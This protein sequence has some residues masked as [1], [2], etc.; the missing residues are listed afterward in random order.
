MI[1][2]VFRMRA[3]PGR[4][5]ELQ[6]HLRQHAIPLVRHQRGLLSFWAGRRGDEFIAVT[7][8]R[9]AV[10]LSAYEQ[11]PVLSEE[12]VPLVAETS[13]EHYALID[14]APRP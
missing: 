5:E 3:K 1:I 12:D 11:N 7:V 6:R 9:D 4:D 2:R 14:G 13:V 10:A 8:W